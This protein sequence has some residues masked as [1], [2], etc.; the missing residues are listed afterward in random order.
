MVA[1]TLPSL[2]EENYIKY[3]IEL[4]ARNIASVA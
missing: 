2:V 1:D 3:F 4:V